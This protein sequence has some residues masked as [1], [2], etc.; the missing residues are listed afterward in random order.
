MTPGFHPYARSLLV[1]SVSLSDG[2]NRSHGL[3][4]LSV[5]QQVKLSDISRKTLP[6]D[7]V[8]DYEDV[9]QQN[10]D[11]SLYLLFILN[12]NIS[13]GRQG[14]NQKIHKN[15]HSMFFLWGLQPYKCIQYYLFKILRY[16]ISGIDIFFIAIIFK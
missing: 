16:I 5:R 12:F 9:K 4:A 15:G 3:P 14:H 7:R 13:P 2:L 8:V 1:G 10:T 11:F 6:R